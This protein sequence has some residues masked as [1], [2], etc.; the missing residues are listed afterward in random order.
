MRG[1][2]GCV[3]KAARRRPCGVGA[4]CGRNSRW[5]SCGMPA[6]GLTFACRSWGG[7][8]QTSR[9]NGFHSFANPPCSPAVSGVG[10]ALCLW[11]WQAMQLAETDYVGT[12]YRGFGVKVA[13]ANL[14]TLCSFSSWGTP[15]HCSVAARP[16]GRTIYQLCAARLPART[17]ARPLVLRLCVAELPGIELAQAGASQPMRVPVIELA[18]EVNIRTAGCASAEGTCPQQLPS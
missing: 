13:A 18:D 11:R 15:L 3:A 10:S 8:M 5:L 4:W 14:C 2:P 16:A 17:Q 9:R 1:E 12:G 6:L 7:L